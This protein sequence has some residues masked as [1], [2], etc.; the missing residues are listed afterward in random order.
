MKPIFKLALLVLLF[1]TYSC[2]DTKTEY[3]TTEAT[4][5][6]EN[7]EVETDSVV[8]DLELEAKD[9]E[10]ELKQLNNDN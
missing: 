5:Q 1:F 9:L 4:K 6:I 10:N 2:R 7:I 8:S 3:T